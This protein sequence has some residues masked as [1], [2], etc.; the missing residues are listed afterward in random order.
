[1]SD[2]QKKLIELARS[3]LGKLYKYGAKL[4]EAPE[5]FD[6]S[7]FVQYL[8]KQIGFDLPRTAL[9]QASIGEVVAPGKEKLQP[10][11]LLFF[12][13]GWGHYN[14]EF[15]DGIGHVGIYI[16][17]DKVIDARSDGKEGGSVIEEPVINF[18]DR[19]DFV[20]TKR[21]I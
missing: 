8:Y 16:G 15:P 14:P 5:S 4:E 12:K 13:G 10:G 7:S 9:A 20:V 11:D 3:L 21:I 18:V 6:C 19:P 1:M 17:E 2:N